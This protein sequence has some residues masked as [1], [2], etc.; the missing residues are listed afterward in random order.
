[1]AKKF[2]HH[3]FL[4]GREKNFGGWFLLF[5]AFPRARATHDALWVYA[6]ISSQIKIDIINDEGE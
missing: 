2:C 3:L 4:V 5:R 6:D 1:M